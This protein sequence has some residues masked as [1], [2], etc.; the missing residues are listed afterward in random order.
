M[1]AYEVIANVLG[2]AADRVVGGGVG[3]GAE[4]EGQI[5]RTL[6]HTSHSADL[7]AIFRYRNHY[8]IQF[9]DSAV[10]GAA[11]MVGGEGSG[12]NLF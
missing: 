9:C 1:E 5:N 2:G 4:A 10:R 7:V 3:V 11:V 12:A 6:I 8:L